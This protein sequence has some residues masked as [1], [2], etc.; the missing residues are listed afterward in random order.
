MKKKTF[1]GIFEDIVWKIV[2]LHSQEYLSKLLKD[3]PEN[4]PQKMLNKCSKEFAKN[5]QE[6][7]FEEISKKIRGEIT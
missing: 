7:F 2:E 5:V 4:L 3:A 1:E 6:Q